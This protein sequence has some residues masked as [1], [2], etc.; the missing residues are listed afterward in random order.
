MASVC[1]ETFIYIFH[2]IFFLFTY[3]IAAARAIRLTVSRA[4]EEKTANN[5]KETCY[6]VHVRLAYGRSAA[7]CSRESAR[8]IRRRKEKEFQVRRSKA[9]KEKLIKGSEN[10]NHNSMLM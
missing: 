10:R 3:F 5:E 2:L 8:S 7:K 1:C 9:A 6:R 4:Q